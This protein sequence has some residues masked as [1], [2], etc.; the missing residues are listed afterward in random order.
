[1]RS[2]IAALTVLVLVAGCGAPSTAPKPHTS[3]AAQQVRASVQEWLA[4]LATPKSAGSSARACSHLTRALQRSI[5]TQ[6]RLHGEH[7]TCETFAAKWTGGSS[8]PGRPGA[9]VAAVAVSGATATATLTAPPDRRSEVRLRRVGGRW[10]I[11][12]Y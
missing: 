1:M 3:A 7:A 4:S 6:L 2:T 10:L 5:D 11:E 8:P 12:N 9:R